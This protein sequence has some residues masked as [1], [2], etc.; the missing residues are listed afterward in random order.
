MICPRCE[1]QGK[2]IIMKEYEYS[3]GG[4]DTGIIDY[5]CPECGYET[6]SC[7]IDKPDYDL[8]SKEE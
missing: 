2:I 3:P 1:E 6:N 7:D 5:E 8:L 4:N